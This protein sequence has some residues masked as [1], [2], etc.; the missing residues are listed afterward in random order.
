ML[1]PRI[2]V[3]DLVQRKVKGILH[4]NGILIDNIEC[5]EEGNGFA[6]V[7][8]LGIKHTVIKVCTHVTNIYS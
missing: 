8:Q 1:N 6:Y 7:F 2:A 4:I 5:D 3:I